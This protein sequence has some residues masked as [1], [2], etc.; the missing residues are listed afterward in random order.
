M[1][2]I[3]VAVFSF[4]FLLKFTSLAIAK[5]VIN[6]ISPASDPEW[7]ELYSDS[8]DSLAQC[9]LY[10]HDGDDTKQKV[11]FVEELNIDKFFVVKKGQYNWSS[12]WLNN[13][14][15][16]VRINCPEGEDSYSYE[17]AGKDTLGRSPDGSGN[18]FVLTSP[19]EGSSNSPPTPPP[20]PKQTATPSSTPTSKP[21]P[22][23]TTTPTNSPSLAPT[24][25]K[26]ADTKKA[27]STP[28][29]T[30]KNQMVKSASDMAVE[31]VAPTSGPSLNEAV[32]TQENEKLNFSIVFVATGLFFILAASLPFVRKL[33]NERHAPDSQ[34]P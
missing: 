29:P 21:T 15:D 19:S 30:S 10:L 18:F 34:I 5:I 17:G 14:G 26:I 2:T 6:E 24:V 1:K 4:L 23:K 16:T 32:D 20:T 8:N 13:G 9:T 31:S 11:D 27:T 28:K 33:Y 12:N 25:L 3:T 7:V 22:E